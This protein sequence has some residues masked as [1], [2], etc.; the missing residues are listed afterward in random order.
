MKYFVEKAE[1]GME[2]FKTNKNESLKIAKELREELDLEYK[3]NSLVRIINTYK[4]HELFSGYYSPAVHEA[5]V[6]V[7]GVMSYEKLFSFLY[8]VKGYMKYYLPSKYRE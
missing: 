5:L 2:L 6:S 4:N 1:K 8:D 3:N 7:T